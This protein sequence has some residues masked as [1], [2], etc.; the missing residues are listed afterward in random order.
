[1]EVAQFLC[2]TVYSVTVLSLM[3]VN[4]TFCSCMHRL[5]LVIHGHWCM[6]G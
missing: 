2:D 3:E 1:M 4:G 5:I 6:Q